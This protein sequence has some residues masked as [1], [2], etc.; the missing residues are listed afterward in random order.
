[1]DN[2]T[3][4]NNNKKN[5]LTTLVVKMCLYFFAVM[6]ITSVFLFVYAGMF[7]GAIADMPQQNEIIFDGVV[8]S[9]DTNKT[10]INMTTDNS[11]VVIERNRN[12]KIY[13]DV[14]TRNM[15]ITPNTYPSEAYTMMYDGDIPKIYT[16]M[17][18]GETYEDFLKNK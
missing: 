2:N 10:D 7:Y 11:F 3:N 15:Y 9:T 1:M 8:A 18:N 14:E 17:I 4:N 5:P 12:Y 6:L 16:G 13:V